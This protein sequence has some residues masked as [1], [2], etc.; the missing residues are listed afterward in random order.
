MKVLSEL[1]APKCYIVKDGGMLPSHISIPQPEGPDLPIVT[2]KVT[3]A[4]KMLYVHFSL[5]EIW[6]LSSTTWFKRALTGLIAF[7]PSKC[8]ETMHGLAFTS[9]FF[10]V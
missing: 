3:T 8:A 4:S 5:A 1:P 7:A 9:D 10:Q 6:Q 2:H